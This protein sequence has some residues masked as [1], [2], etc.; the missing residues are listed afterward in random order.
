MF[1]AVKVPNKRKFENPEI[2]DKDGKKITKCNDI[3]K[4]VTGHFKENFRNDNIIQYTCIND[5]HVFKGQP[6]PLLS[7]ITKKKVRNSINQ[8]NNGKCPQWMK[9]A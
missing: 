7:A 3:H 5:I 8:P 4:I 6:R 9:C 1:T 2:E